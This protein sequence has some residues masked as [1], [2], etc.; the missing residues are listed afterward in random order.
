MTKSADGHKTMA[1]NVSNSVDYVSQIN[2]LAAK[3][4]SL[5]DWQWNTIRNY[6]AQGQ[7]CM[8]DF[9]DSVKP[10]GE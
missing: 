8:F 4:A 5:S 2:F 3:F 7:L 9:W 10:E 6:T 1:Y